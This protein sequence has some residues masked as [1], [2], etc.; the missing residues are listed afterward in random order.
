MHERERPDAQAVIVVDLQT[1]MF[2]SP[3]L[4]RIHDADAIVDRVRSVIAWARRTGRKVVFI[5]H[6]GPPG[7]PL[8]PNE[9]GWPLWPALGRNDDEP[10][11]SKTV[12]DAFS[13]PRLVDWLAREGVETVIF[14]GAQS[15]FCV[16]ATVRGALE[17]RLRVYV[18][19]DAHST[20]DAEGETAQRIV[21]R[22]NVA[23]ANAGASVIDT[24]TITRL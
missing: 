18:V 13:Q 2:A 10:I 7:D 14:V 24:A 3:F 21:A 5:R 19:G 1:D 9:P 23:F 22:H 20:W 6:D 12:G 11:F 16:A 4:P 15:D 8:A 17:R